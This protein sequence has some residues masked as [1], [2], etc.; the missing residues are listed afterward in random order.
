VRIGGLGRVVQY[1]PQDFVCPGETSGHGNGSELG[2]CKNVKP[3]GD[4]PAVGSKVP[5]IGT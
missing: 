1:P 5:G 3:V 4:P 2:D